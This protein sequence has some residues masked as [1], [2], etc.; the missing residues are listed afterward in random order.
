MGL[1]LYF[2]SDNEYI[3]DV[4]IGKTSGGAIC[5]CLMNDF[6]YSLDDLDNGVWI[7]YDKFQE[8]IK[9]LE[10]KYGECLGGMLTKCEWNDIKYVG[11]REGRLKIL[12]SR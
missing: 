3:P 4:W 1:S 2:Y 8:V 6:G 9:F 12:V 10:R 5:R 7:S 11:I